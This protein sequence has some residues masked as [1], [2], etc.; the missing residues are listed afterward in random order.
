MFFASDYTFA[1]TAPDLGKQAPAATTLKEKPA[2]AKKDLT[3]LDVPPSRMIGDAERA[4]YIKTITATLA[5]RTQTLDPFCLHQDPES[6]PAVRVIN[7]ALATRKAVPA[8]PFSD[9]VKLIKVTTVMPGEDGFLVGT[10]LFRVNDVL[11]LSFR[12][13]TY[14]VQIT[15]VTSARI[16]FKNTENGEIGH[17]ELNLLPAGMSKGDGGIQIPGLVPSNQQAPLELESTSP[18]EDSSSS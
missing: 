11:P 4:G 2:A 16:S 12:G 8:T 3:A 7:N 14:R 15:A 10:R 1:K 5:I 17:L 6:K 13:K 9:I 18:T